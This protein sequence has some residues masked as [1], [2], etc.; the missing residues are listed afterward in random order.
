MYSADFIKSEILNILKVFS[1]YCKEHGL[2]YVT[3]DQEEAFSLSD[4]IMVMS[5]AHIVQMDTPHNIILHPS[6]QYVKDFVIENLKIKIDSLAV[7]IE[8]LNHE[9]K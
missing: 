3:H 2:G 4:R 5:D 6:D 1:A 8:D 7:Y 9:E